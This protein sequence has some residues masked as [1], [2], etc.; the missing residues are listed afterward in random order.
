[1]AI[2]LLVLFGALVLAKTVANPGTQ[3]RSN[4]QKEGVVGHVWVDFPA[5]TPTKILRW[6]MWLLCMCTCR[7]GATAATAVESV[8][9]M[10][11][12]ASFTTCVNG[13]SSGIKVVHKDARYLS[14]VDIRD[15]NTSQSIKPAD[16][17]VFE[18]TT[19]LATRTGLQATTTKAALMITSFALACSLAGS[20]AVGGFKALL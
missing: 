14:P 15:Q 7:A 2:L 20:W 10:A 6:N 1:M 8:R 4:L 19:L 3:R 16:L 11:D 18:V 13:Y 9:H 5:T 12:T 17:A